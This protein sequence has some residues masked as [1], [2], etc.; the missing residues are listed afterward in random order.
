VLSAFRRLCSSLRHRLDL[1]QARRAH[2]AASRARADFSHVL[3]RVI[4]EA[5]YGKELCDGSSDSQNIAHCVA[6]GLCHQKVFDWIESFERAR[7]AQIRVHREALVDRPE[8][9]SLADQCAVSDF[10]PIREVDDAVAGNDSEV[11]RRRAAYDAVRQ[12]QADFQEPSEASIAL[13]RK[14]IAQ[15]R[16]EIAA[17][18]RDKGGFKLTLNL[19]TITNGLALM[20]SALVIGGFLYCRS[21]F[22]YFDISTNL[23]FQLGD[24]LATSLENTYAALLTA[25]GAVLNMFIY[26][27][28]DAATRPLQ[29]PPAEKRSPLLLY[30]IVVL[31]LVPLISH[32]LDDDPAAWRDLYFVIFFL[33][34]GLS[35]YAHRYITNP[36]GPTFAFAFLGA[37]FAAALCNAQYDARMAAAGRLP[38]VSGI[39]LRD[40][41]G[42]LVTG[43]NVHVIAANSGYFFLWDS[44]KGVAIPMARSDV[45]EIRTR[46]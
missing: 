22:S 21:F 15:R 42:H 6:R 41:A 25:G 34:F 10:W 36:L 40:S 9:Q 29:P 16:R 35:S 11:T 45:S 38:P 31:P 2:V 12:R 37:F 3:T 46:R 24:Y 8:V 30:L 5:V 18:E 13:L 1:R 27:R 20:S 7:Q 17:Q 23:F 33:F 43:G 32:L 4:H 19:G 26:F 28:R 44:E 39:Q 14:S